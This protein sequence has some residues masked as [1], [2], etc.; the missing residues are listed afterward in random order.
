MR[1]MQNLIVVIVLVVMLTATNCT[2]TVL[3]KMSALGMLNKPVNAF[4]VWK[5]ECST[6]IYGPFSLLDSAV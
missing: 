4:W 1:K 6:C 3:E 5:L 2:Y